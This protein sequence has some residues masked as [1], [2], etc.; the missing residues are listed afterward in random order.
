DEQIE[1]DQVERLRSVR[2]KRNLVSAEKALSSL[3]EAAAGEENLLPR[4][5]ECVENEL[6]VG[7]ISHCLRKVWGEYR[8]AVTV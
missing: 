5:L 3:R 7:E 6:T 2:E 4:I 8:E 1:R